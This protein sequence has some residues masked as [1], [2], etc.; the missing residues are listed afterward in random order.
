MYERIRIQNY[1]FVIHEDLPVV[2]IN[3]K[4]AINTEM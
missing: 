4:E 2:I 1:Y 3:Q